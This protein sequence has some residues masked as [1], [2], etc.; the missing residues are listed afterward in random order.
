[1]MCPDTAYASTCGIVLAAGLSRRMGRFKPLLPIDG[2]RVLDHLE[3][4]ALP[5]LGERG[6]QRPRYLGAGCVARGVSHSSPAVGRLLAQ[7]ELA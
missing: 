5:G 1:M 2:E 7:V 3:F 6:K 4:C